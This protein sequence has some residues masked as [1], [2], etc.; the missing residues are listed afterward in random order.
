ML[1]LDDQV[2]IVFSGFVVAV[3]FIS[4]PVTNAIESASNSMVSVT[5]TSQ[6]A[7]APPFVVA[8]II[9]LPPATPETAVTTPFWSTVAIFSL[10]DDHVTVESADFTVALNCSV[11]SATN[12]IFVLFNTI[13]SFTVTVQVAVA[14]PTPSFPPAVVA[15]IVA[16]PFPTAVTLPSLSTVT[17]F[18]SLDSHVIVVVSGVVFAVNFVVSL[19][20]SES[21]FSNSK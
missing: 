11:D 18:E 14:L 20:S 17:T 1:S 9:A 10:S 21:S 19:T 16:V 12:S 6:V 4:V 2:T 5:V 8:V 7:V 15:V 3:N 13:E